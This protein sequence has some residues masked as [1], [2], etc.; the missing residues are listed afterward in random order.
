MTSRR[1]FTLV[2]MLLVVA[3]L[4]LL[5]AILL[6]QIGKARGVAQEAQCK[7][8]MRQIG[9]AFIAFA[10]NN[11]QTLPAASHGGWEG[12]EAWQKCWVGKEGR[13][14][15]LFEPA[16]DG[17]LVKYLGGGGNGTRA[18]FRCPALNVTPRYGGG[19]NGGF[20]YTMTLSFSG[21]RIRTVPLE[22]RII[23][24]STPFAP[25]IANLRTPLLVEE[26]PAYHCNSISIE[27][28]FGSIDR[29]SSHHVTRG[30]PYV[31]MDGGVETIMFNASRPPEAWEWFVTTRRGVEVRLNDGG[32]TYAFWKTK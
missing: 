21:A 2:E 4:S 25:S 13:V 3:I 16:N 17:P 1:A 5:I 8:Q 14:P 26:D 22:A 15:G 11:G 7:A 9:D 20:D 12:A 19:S 30:S 28:G 24:M 32:V 27:P 6:P 31:A 10:L 23:Y 29:H 18:F